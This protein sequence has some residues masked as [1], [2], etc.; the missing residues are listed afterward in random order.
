LAAGEGLEERV[1]LERVVDLGFAMYVCNMIYIH[2][3]NADPHAKQQ[4]QNQL[5]TLWPA[6]KGSLAKVHK[7]CIRKN[8]PACARGD[9]HQAWLLSFSSQGQRKTRYVPLAMVPVLEKALKN[10]R[11]IE[12]LLCR[13]GPDLLQQYRQT[14]KKD[15]PP[16]TKS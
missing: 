6:V 14:V 7:P 15:L 12:Q 5:A 10:G 4:W 2:T 16:G 9:K 1:F 8:C 13:A 11:Q 3:M